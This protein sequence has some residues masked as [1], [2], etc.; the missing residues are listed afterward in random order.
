MET[1][2]VI[3]FVT[4]AIENETEGTISDENGFFKIENICEKEFNLIISHVG[5]KTAIHHHDSYH[6]NPTIFLA[7]DDK[8]LESV[9]VE[10]DYNPTSLNSVKISKLSEQDFELSKSESFGDM[11][12]QIAGVSTISTGQ[13]IVKPIIHGLHSNRVLIINNGVRHEFQNWGVEHGPEI[14]P[15][16]AGSLEVVK[17]AATVRYGPD[18][19][20]GVI[21]IN[22]PKM[23]L[24]SGFKGSVGATGKSNGRSGESNMGLSYG[25]NHLVLSAQGSIVEQGD[26]KA[27]DYQLTNTGKK[28]NSFSGGFRLH[29]GAFDFEGYYSR[30]QQNLGILRGSVNGNLEDL[31]QAINRSEPAE[32]AP[33]SYKINSPRQEV[34]H[35]LLKLKGSY[36]MDNQEFSFQY[37]YQFNHRQEFDVRRGA[38]NDIPSIDLELASQ[39][40]DFD[41]NHPNLGQFQGKMGVQWVYQDNNNIPGTN[42][43][44]FVPNYN[45]T[46]VGVYAIE[47]LDFGETTYEGGIRYDYQY[48][49]VRGR[50]P[51]NDLFINTLTFNQVTGSL[52]LKREIRSHLDFR[53]NVGMAWRPPNI[54]ELYSFGKHQASFEYGL[55]RYQ[56]DQ[57]NNV[58]VQGV[59]TEEDKTINSEVG[60]KW[61]NSFEYNSGGKQAELTSYANL[62]KNYIYTRPGGITNTVRGAFPYF[63]H[64]Q[65]DALFLGVDASAREEVIDNLELEGQVSYIWARNIST[66]DSFTEIPPV[67]IN[68]GIHF[69]KKPDFLT[70]SVLSLTQSYTFPYFQQ[71]RTITP[72]EI[73]DAKSNEIDLFKE[74]D[75]N[76]DFLDAPKGYF[77]TNVSWNAE[78]GHWG[79]AF[80]VKNLFNTRYRLNTDRLRYFADQTARNIQL[81]VSY[82]I[83]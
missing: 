78:V 73:L 59:L 15:S 28:E 61:I 67:K 32:T 8:V 24:S 37:A 35:S 10:G 58:T 79:W 29:K 34:S 41:W 48:S 16:L 4:V 26:L 80:Q 62:I 66:N 75:S 76:F 69:D 18:A 57:F 1:K 39:S 2:E 81:S 55:W 49:S 36:I 19:L 14:D 38:L 54:S 11:A 47:K 52:G 46:R 83:H 74:D 82:S 27:P 50:E 5:Y 13:N 21:L 77:I 68:V 63:V 40:V 51:N 12:G 43:V 53:S 31:I 65:D 6:N 30:F 33:F 3:P 25:W 64:D 71:P 60:F 44:P 20:G 23:E 7:H 22:P 9:V 56:L 42:T 70:K 45:N 17:G 72:Q